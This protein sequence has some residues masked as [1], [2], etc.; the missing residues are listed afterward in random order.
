MSSPE[1]HLSQPVGIFRDRL[2]VVRLQIC[3]RKSNKV[4]AKKVLV[5]CQ[6]CDTFTADLDILALEVDE[7]AGY[8]DQL[9][10]GEEFNLTTELLE[11]RNIVNVQITK[12]KGIRTSVVVR[13]RTFC[14]HR[15]QS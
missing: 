8:L 2:K 12:K 10:D 5:L 1:S 11:G 7:R 3:L 4:L 13:L 6:D 9:G 15:Y 14:Q